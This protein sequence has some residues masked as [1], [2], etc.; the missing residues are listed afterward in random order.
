MEMFEAYSEDLI[1]SSIVHIDRSYVDIGKKI[2]ADI[3][4]SVHSQI[5]SA[6]EYRYILG[7]VAI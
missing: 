7:S 5:V 1:D 6:R 2:F 3:N 4:G